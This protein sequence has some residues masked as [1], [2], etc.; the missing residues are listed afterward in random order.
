MYRFAKSNNSVRVIVLLMTFILVGTNMSVL[1]GSDRIFPSEKITLYSGDQVIGVYTKEAPLPE[2]AIISTEGRC[3]VRL[4]D[5]YLVAEDQSV[6]SIS[7]SG[8]QRNMFIRQGIVYF[9][10]AAIKHQLSFVTPNGQINVQQIRINA[11]FDDSTVK[12]YVAVTEKQSEIGVAEGGSLDVFTDK[13]LMTIKPGKKIILSQA[14]MDIG[15][16]EGEEPAAQEPAAEPPPETKTGWSTGQK[17]AVGV[18]GVGAI[19]G[20]MLG[21]SGGGGG[22]GGG[23]SVSPSSP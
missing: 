2:H 22:D 15:L 13:G 14:D 3:A 11:A 10:T 5:L 18:L 7:T 1:A 12:G 17:V 6:F 9:K 21:L 23:G 4:E 20:I 19:T 8:R 16:P